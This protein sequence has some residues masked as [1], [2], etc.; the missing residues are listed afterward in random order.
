MERWKRR[1]DGLRLDWRITAHD[2]KC[3]IGDKDNNADTL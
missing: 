1:D 3:C 2:G